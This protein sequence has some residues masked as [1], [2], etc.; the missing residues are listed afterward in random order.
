MA[1]TENWMEGGGDAGQSYG[2]MAAP[3]VVVIRGRKKGL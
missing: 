3:K 1:T 2:V